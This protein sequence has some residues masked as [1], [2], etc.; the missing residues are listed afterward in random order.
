MRIFIADDSKILRESLISILS[1]IEGIEIVGEEGNA[2]R[3]LPAVLRLSPDI[4]ILDIHIPERNGIL[5]LEDIKKM[6]NPPIVIMFTNYPY[7][8]YRKECINAGADYFL[9]KSSES[10]KLIN[11]IKAAVRSQ[12]HMEA[13]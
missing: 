10:E 8:Q 3:V 12:E 6:E 5:I 11:I 7:L 9:Y 1:E 13:E 2:T 4:V